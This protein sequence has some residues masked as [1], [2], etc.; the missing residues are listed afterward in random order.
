MPFEFPIAPPPIR[1]QVFW[2]RR[3]VGL[4]GR[5]IKR[6]EWTPTSEP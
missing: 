6:E 1:V 4:S 2:L 3:L 5:A